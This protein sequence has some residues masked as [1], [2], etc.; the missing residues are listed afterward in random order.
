MGRP[1]VKWEAMWLVFRQL[2]GCLQDPRHRFI[3]HVMAWDGRARLISVMANNF[4]GSLSLC[5][6]ITHKHYQYHAIPA[7]YT[8][9]EHNAF[10]PLHKNA[11]ALR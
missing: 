3:S 6:V 1:R 8:R 2:F 4:S 9:A 11:D 5:Q 7:V 10:S